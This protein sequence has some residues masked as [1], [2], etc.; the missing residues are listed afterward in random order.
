M[1]IVSD[2]PSQGLG[3]VPVFFLNLE[4]LVSGALG[5]SFES[6]RSMLAVLVTGL[7]FPLGGV[8]EELVTHGRVF[9]L[10][11]SVSLIKY[12]TTLFPI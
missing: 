9:F 11:F 10:W 6:T 4:V 5:E 1:S 12:R 2:T 7:V 3:E 8:V